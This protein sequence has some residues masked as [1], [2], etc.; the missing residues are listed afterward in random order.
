VVRSPR[1]ERHE[2]GARAALV[3]LFACT[4]Q[5]RRE[6]IGHDLAMLVAERGTH[7]D[8]RA[9]LPRDRLEVRRPH[10]SQ[11]CPRRRETRERAPLARWLAELVA[12]RGELGLLLASIGEKLAELVAQRVELAWLLASIGRER[13]ELVTQRVEQVALLAELLV[14]G[15]KQTVRSWRACRPARSANRRSR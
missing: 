4:L 1:G 5:E 8:E 7:G 12:P 13:A 14:E 2:L 3:E 6:R 15:A 10:R 11:R 9:A